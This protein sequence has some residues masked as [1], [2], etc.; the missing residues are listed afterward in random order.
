ME[1]S[2]IL[3]TLQ[4]LGLNEY[5]SRVYTSLAILGPSKAG[6]VSKHAEVPQ[7]K[8]YDILETLMRK[9]MIEV[10]E[11]RPKEFRA[12]APEVVIK[13]MI[14]EREQQL[15]FL[16]ERANLVGSLLR[17]STDEED[18]L[19]GTWEQRGEKFMEVLN[20]LAEML[21][22]AENYVID[23]TRDFSSS[24]RFREA[25]RSC[26]KRKVKIM[27]ISMDINDENY[28]KAKWYYSNKIPIKIFET[29]VHPRILVVDGKE[30]ALRLDSNPL[31]KR[32]KFRSIWSA[33]PSFVAVMDSYM[34]N[35]WKMAKP[36]DFRK[37]PA[38]KIQETLA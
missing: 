17:P 19:E 30:V 34:K 28:Y 6:D 18:V 23:I 10:F 31:K 1:K 16:K 29:K 25:I 12:V 7:S 32:F 2:E 36:V 13:N 38:P 33:D 14:D 37:I 35:M 15:K 20:K 5:E 8:I 22:R 9:Q 26:I 11:D 27:V 24:Q 4:S 21:N 3:K